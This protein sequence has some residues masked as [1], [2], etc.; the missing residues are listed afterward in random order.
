[1][2]V[3]THGALDHPLPFRHGGQRDH[4]IDRVQP[5]DGTPRPTPPRPAPSPG[6]FTPPREGGIEAQT[7]PRPGRALSAPC[8]PFPPPRSPRRLPGQGRATVHAFD[9]GGRKRCDILLREIRPFLECA[10]GQPHG[11][12]EDRTP[13]PRPREPARTSCPPQPRRDFGQDPDTA[14]LRRPAR[15]PIFEAHGGRVYPHAIAPT[16]AHA[17]LPQPRDALGM[18][19]VGAQTAEIEDVGAKRPQDRPDRRAWDHGSA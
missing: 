19:P 11:M 15:P 7:P 18:G 1:M 16:L 17:G 5:R 9:P 12:G 8:Q 2:T 10:P 6:I 14:D 13:L 4:R 3:P